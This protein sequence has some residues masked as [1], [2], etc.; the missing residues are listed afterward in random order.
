MSQFGV[1]LRFEL[2]FR[3]N[4]I[5]LWIFAG[6]CFL[7][8]FLSITIDQ[9]M[10]PFG[11][12]GAI[13]INAPVVVTEMMLVYCVLLG[14]PIVTGFV[15]TAVIRDQEL[16]MQ[17]LF[18]ATPLRKIPYLAGRFS[19]SFLATSLAVAMLA[20]GT[21]FGSLMPWLDHER[22]VPFSL[23][24]YGYALGV[25]VVPNL[26]FLGSVTFAVAT[27]TGRQIYAYVALLG[28]LV[29]YSVSSAFIDDL[30]HDFI[31]AVIDP[32]AMRTYGFAIRYWTT[33]EMNS[34]AAPWTPE[35]AINRLL[36]VGVSVAALLITAVRA[37]WA[38]SSRERRTKIDPPGTSE[39]T[40][41][42]AS[43]LPSS[44][45]LTGL[46]HAR[47]A[48]LAQT[49]FE[50]RGL[51]RS[52][53]FVVIALFCIGNV[54]A[55]SFG[56]I[57][58][59]GT[60]TLP[61]TH[62]MVD[63]IAG[64]TAL[65]VLIVLVFYAGELV[66]QERKH[67]VDELFDALPVPSWIPLATKL[68]AMLLG[69]FVLFLAS[70]TTVMIFQVAKGYTAIE[71]GLYLRDILLVQ[72][73]QW[74]MLA[75]AA[76]A[77]QVVIN[78]KFLGYGAMA[79]LFAMQSAL[80]ALDFEHNIYNYAGLPIVTYS[81]MNGYG[82]YSAP[83]AAFSVYWLLAAFVL[84]LLAEVF[85]VRGK[86]TPFRR[87]LT[88]VRRRMQR[89]RG[90]AMTVLVV[91]W[92]GAG[93]WILY[94]TL[95]L[96]TY[97]PSDELEDR[98]ALYEN[99]Y[100][101]YEGLPQPRI[102]AV[103]LDAAL[104]PY[105][106]KLE[107]RGTLRAVNET[108]QA[109]REL[110]VCGSDPDVKIAALD[111]PGATLRHDG[112]DVPYRIYDLAEPLL[113]AQ[114]LEIEFDFRKSFSGFPN[115][116]TDTSIVANGTF[117]H[118]GVWLPHF[119][120][121][122]N[123]E[124]TE[125]NKRRDRGLPKR[126]RMAKIDD[127]SAHGNT[128]LAQDSD[129]IE[130]DATVSTAADQIAIA[131]GYLTREWREGERRFFRYEMDRPML[132]FWAILS[133]RYEVSRDTWVPRDGGDPVAVEIFFH[134]AHA[135][136]VEKMKTA[137]KASLDRFTRV[138]SPYQ[139]RQVRII[140]FPKYASF[141]QSFPNTIPYS[142]NLGF[143]ANPNL[144]DDEIDY[145][146]YVT[147]H[148]VAHQW[149]A[150]QAIGANVQGATLLSESL[151]QY[152]ALCVMEDMY[153]EDALPRF[154]RHELNRYLGRRSAEDIE[155]KTLLLVE[156]Q[157]YIH[158]N[159]GS[160][161]FYALKEYIGEEPLNEAL[162][163]FLSEVAFQEPPFTVST[164]LYVH[165]QKATPAR[166]QYLLEDMFE[167]IT[168]YDNRALSAKARHRDDGKFELSLEVQVKKAY[169]DGKGVETE[170]PVAGEW[171]EVGAY[172]D[173]RPIYLELHRFDG[174]ATVELVLDEAPTKAGIDPRNLL[175][176]RGPDDNRKAVELV[177]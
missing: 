67:R 56:F 97:R 120:Y 23:A 116:V 121:D 3:R 145:V 113:P 79:L 64:A 109:L 58:Q 30:D 146:V 53:P 16:G 24:P 65:F 49:R 14:F 112:G 21:A 132:N 55:A 25:L 73:P 96:N 135:F 102:V 11:G 123:A 83:R 41:P 34:V 140:E 149:W 31:A 143:I 138:F 12:R 9:G 141:A 126:E 80:P 46:R 95:V 128:M 103:D 52:I 114:A 70:A 37:P 164:D 130:F 170:T 122:R 60:E 75:V 161:V 162:R 15:A 104:Y 77:A 134:P 101:R 90:V 144:D 92:L 22:L 10:T 133:A 59:L 54:L 72:M 137:T 174:N 127:T 88:E 50:I 42:V 152:S 99:E 36:W 167:K 87:R 175:I 63:V 91:A 18:M 78:H 125:P 86:D 39:S 45:A 108:G 62:L 107:V 153:G 57:E 51:L 29:V 2:A 33:A 118:S 163:T 129:W 44:T 8:A 151:A 13:A 171:I 7:V 35:L 26:F 28:L 160:L 169:A 148:E 117:I 1:V 159:K 20:A 172:V 85:W 66:H 111:I 71:G 177:D 69:I 158:Y 119:G 131:P 43:P 166:L 176:D 142:E 168:L 19:G 100:K 106:R 84:V 76:L 173:E 82:P 38:L 89:G 68:I 154:L 40:T 47:E 94:N 157:Q 61:V 105:D 81:D 6:L 32:F 17:S 139:H 150:H 93:G 27:L 136:N 115:E 124:L 98:Q 5:P 165:L 110:H 155:E 48:F 156:N 74:F 4:S 147:A